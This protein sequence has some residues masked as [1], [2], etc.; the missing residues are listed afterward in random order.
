M[1]A[2]QDATID[3]I[4]FREVRSLAA[5][6][7]MQARLL[8]TKLDQP[9]QRANYLTAVATS[10]LK[11]EKLTTSAYLCDPLRFCVGKP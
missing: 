6:D 1:T 5:Q 10:V 3:S 7:Y 11:T 8:A 4:D 2:S 9:L